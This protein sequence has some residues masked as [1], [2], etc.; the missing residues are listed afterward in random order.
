MR[1]IFTKDYEEKMA[2]NYKNPPRFDEDD[3][4]CWKNEIKIWTMMTELPKNK[5]ALAVSLSLNGNAKRAAM[6]I[7]VETLN[8]DEGMSNLLETLDN[9]FLKDSLDSMYEA[10]QNF[11]KF[12]RPEN[13]SI[14]E[15]IIEFDQ[16]YL[17]STKFEM[18]LPDPVLAFKL[19]DKSGLDYQQRQLALTAC[20]SS[21]L[22]YKNMKSALKR[23]FGESN[24]AGPYN[25]EPIVKQETALYATLKKKKYHNFPKSDTGGSNRFKNGNPPN[26]YGKITR[27]SICQ[28][29]LH[30][31]REC[32][33]KNESIRL[34]ET[35]K[36][37]PKETD[38]EECNITLFTYDEHSSNEIFL[39]ESMNMAVIDTACTRTVCG[40]K[41]LDEYKKNINKEDIV[42]QRSN[43]PFRFGDGKI[44][45][46]STRVTLP[47]KIGST[48]CNINA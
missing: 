25:E 28:S 30:W 3:Y 24:V 36:S 19:L 22:K 4:S 20:A 44:I 38:V 17:K 5:Q 13:M 16:R 14:S 37:D 31:W 39:V 46:S 8:T 26:R 23:I 11:D 9:L 2:S 7:A 41:W 10:Y 32:P 18:T 43:V 12:Q 40:Q 21:E 1:T 48:K 29:V 34:T 15:Y 35:D 6:G 27:C 33:H 45:N 47:A 42:I